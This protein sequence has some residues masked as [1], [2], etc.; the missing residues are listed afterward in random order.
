[1][2]KYASTTGNGAESDCV[3]CGAGKY[4]ETEGN[5]E[6]EPVDPDTVLV[7]YVPQISDPLDTSNFDEFPSEDNSRWDKY[8]S[9]EFEGVWA[10]EFGEITGLAG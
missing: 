9:P 6:E 5:D 10:K 4:L 2:G 3:S 8:N 1:M 7:P